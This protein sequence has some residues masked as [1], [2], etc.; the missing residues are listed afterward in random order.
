MFR[1]IE[2]SSALSSVMVAN[3]P[4]V[5]LLPTLLETP[6]STQASPRHQSG[7]VQ[8]SQTGSRTYLQVLAPEYAAESLRSRSQKSRTKATKT[9]VLLPRAQSSALVLGLQ[10]VIDPSGGG[11]RASSSHQKAHLSK[12]S[13]GDRDPKYRRQQ[14][15]RSSARKTPRRHTSQETEYQ[16]QSRIEGAKRHE[17]NRKAKLEAIRRKNLRDSD[18]KQRIAQIQRLEA[19]LRKE[20][21]VRNKDIEEAHI[22]IGLP[23]HL[24]KYMRYVSKVNDEK[25]SQKTVIEEESKIRRYQNASFEDR[26]AEERSADLNRELQLLKLQDKSRQVEALKQ[27]RLEH[28]IKPHSDLLH[29]PDKYE[30]L[31]SF[32]SSLQFENELKDVVWKRYQRVIPDKFKPLTKNKRKVI[33]AVE[34][35]EKNEVNRYIRNKRY[36]E[37]DGNQSSE[38]L[39]NIGY[40]FP[41][42]QEVSSDVQRPYVIYQDKDYSDRS[43]GAYVYFKRSS[44]EISSEI[45]DNQEYCFPFVEEA[46]N[47]RSKFKLPEINVHNIIEWREKVLVELR[48]ENPNF[49]IVLQYEQ[50]R[51]YSSVEDARIRQ[52]LNPVPAGAVPIADLHAAVTD[53]AY[54]RPAAT[55]AY[56]LLNFSEREEKYIFYN[57]KLYG[58]IEKSCEAC[59]EAVV[60]LKQRMVA[61]E[62]AGGDLT[63][64]NGRTLLV[65]IVE[66]FKR[67]TIRTKGE[68]IKS[69]YSR[70]IGDP[71]C[72]KGMDLCTVLEKDSIELLRLEEFNEATVGPKLIDRFIDAINEDQKYNGLVGHLRTQRE[73]PV[74]GLT[75]TRLKAIVKKDDIDRDADL[76]KRLKRNRDDRKL[77]D[78]KSVITCTNCG[79][80][81]HYASVCR[82][83]KPNAKALEVTKKVSTGAKRGKYGEP[84]KRSD[85]DKPWT[86]RCFKCG[87]PHMVRDC[88]LNRQKG[89]EAHSL[90]NI[91]SGYYSTKSA[92]EREVVL[93]MC[94]ESTSSSTE[95]SSREDSFEGNSRVWSS[96]A[97]DAYADELARFSR[98]DHRDNCEC[99]DYEDENNQNTVFVSDDDLNGDYV[100]FLRSQIVDQTGEIFTP[101]SDNDI[102]VE[103]ARRSYWDVLSTL[104]TEHPIVGKSV[105][106]LKVREACLRELLARDES[107]EEVRCGPKR[108]RAAVDVV[109]TNR[110]NDKDDEDDY[111]VARSSDD[112]EVPRKDA[113]LIDH[114]GCAK[115][116]FE[117]HRNNR[118]TVSLLDTGASKCMFRDRGSFDFLK[119]TNYGISTASSTLRVTEAGPVKCIKEAYHLPNATH[120]LISIGDLDDLGCKIEIEGGVLTLSRNGYTILDVEKSNNVWTA[121]TAEVLDGVLTTMSDKEKADMWWLP[122]F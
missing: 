71:G 119:K 35:R 65:D 23:E 53:L 75:W 95:S 32:S 108:M 66:L 60:F 18:M 116:A 118:G 112:W 85:Q 4:G 10:P 30:G 98:C 37:Q 67:D 49:T 61:F 48:A 104:S 102:D 117:A 29:S 39:A 52:L 84:T 38:S 77:A 90:V 31:E 9:K 76:S 105:E 82:K 28:W 64:L 12:T 86:P 24:K 8:A 11:Y 96:S 94:V 120:D 72:R 92:S 25:I 109:P 62:V 56:N 51:W 101:F 36:R 17:A 59:L 93:A 89:G 58:L 100:Y 79:K 26:I 70:C 121:P 81:G 68:K 42:I 88:G 2:A 97:F 73:D 103:L 22:R 14:C 78:E 63:N 74:N 80:R 1:A 107:D 20:A 46:K 57:S 50:P 13:R 5:G 19:R 83:K 21:N 114:L 45:Q 43:N 111:A 113:N 40:C 7:R 122:S 16:I 47:Q 55:A 41:F 115:V 44:E 33:E 15:H 27:E 34:T 106:Y 3:E 6:V 69:F 87:G 110:R 99:V 91:P 54:R